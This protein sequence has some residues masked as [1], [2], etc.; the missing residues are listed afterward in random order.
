M[1][2]NPDMLFRGVM[3]DRKA[4]F[5]HPGMWYMLIAFPGL[6]HVQPPRPLL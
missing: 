3:A 2:L 4:S 5:T 1:D 6:D